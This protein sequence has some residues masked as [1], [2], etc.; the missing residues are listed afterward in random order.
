MT[1]FTHD[2]PAGLPE[3][4]AAT[5]GGEITRLERHVARREAWVVDVTRP[6]GTVLEAFLR[7]EREPTAGNPW[8]LEKETRIVQALGPTAVPVPAV[9]GWNAELTATLF[10]RVPGRGD[11]DH[12]DDARQQRAVFEDFMH[13]VAELHT[14]DI[15]ALGLDDLPGMYRPATPQECA[16]A[17]MDLILDQWKGFLD[18]FTEPLITYGVD[19]LRRFAPTAVA[20]ISLVQGDTGP[21]NFVF[22]GDRV[23]AVVDWEWGHFGDPMEDLGN[24]CVRE[25]WNPCG[26]L[27]GLFPMYEKLSGIP[28]DPAAVRYYR[29]Q[30]N[31]RGMVPIDAVTVQASHR[32]P[33]AWFLAYRCV[34]DRS[35]CEA[36]AEAMGIT[37]ARPEL[38]PDDD[39]DDV[40]AA[41]AV[42]ILDH[43]VAPHVSGAFPQSRVTDATRLVRCLERKRRLGPAL[44]VIER[45]ELGAL[46]GRTPASVEDGLR[47]LDAAVRDHGLADDAVLPYLTRRAWRSEF[48]YAPAVELYPNRTWSPIE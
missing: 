23:T 26:G 1:T 24:I 25:F 44:D 11:L 42:H 19:W 5:G 28:F 45:D 4:V 18:S 20:R 48:L 43:D 15:D 37:V 36:M 41:A 10:E 40:L 47:D 14:L 35:T 16:L 38:P 31:V 22:D 27:D 17:E 33:I 7:L 46:L 3:W 21:V 2:L 8:S 34:N 13:A 6:D 9:H 32:E 29:V 30:Q 39:G 12:V